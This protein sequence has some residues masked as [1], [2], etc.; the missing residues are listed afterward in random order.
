VAG[1]ADASSGSSAS[2]DDP[3]DDRL[4]FERVTRAD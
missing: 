4:N 1:G 3:G 2:T